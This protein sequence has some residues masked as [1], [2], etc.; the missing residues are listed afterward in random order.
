MSESEQGIHDRVLE[1]YKDLPFN[2]Y[3]RADDAAAAI[4]RHNQ[5]A[6]WYQDLDSILKNAQLQSILD[7][8]CG[9]GWFT[10]TVARYYNIETLGIDFNPVAIEKAIATS[11]A[12]TID[13]VSF[14]VWDLF[15]LK[16]L[17][18]TFDLVSSI[19]VLHHTA[20][21]F[22]GIRS[23]ASVLSQNPNSRLYIGL[24]HL[25]GRRPFLEYFEQK[26][27]AGFSEEQL[28]QAYKELH[29]QITDEEHLKSWFRDQV[30]HPH[31]SQHTLH[32]VASFL[33]SLGFSIESTS[34]NRFEP[35]GN[36]LQLYEEEMKLEQLSY[37]RN[38]V[39]NKYYPGFFTV[40]AKRKI[41]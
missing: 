34:I 19:G 10:N 30:L 14:K 36:L 21:P 32:E 28:L 11:N 27:R 8:G 35:I 7:V 31:E 3:A 20:D 37:Q 16:D 15:K 12:L 23:M 9:P 1:F 38:F 17:G 33:D 5:I 41:S 39:E 29:S 22:G 4:V 25:Y 18:F 2:A 13:K 6:L 40:C 24:Y 26:K